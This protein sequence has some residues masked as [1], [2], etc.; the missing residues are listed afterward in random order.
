MARALIYP[1]LA[2]E[3]DLEGNVTVTIAIDEKGIIHEATAISDNP[4]V[5]FEEA[6]IA[7]VMAVKWEPAYQRDRPVVF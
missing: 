2:R 5:G 1:E 3:T 4:K 6:A 7:A